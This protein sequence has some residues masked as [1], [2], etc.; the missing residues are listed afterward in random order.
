M[1]GFSNDWEFTTEW[2]EEFAR[3][4]GT[5]E[6]VRLPH[7]VKELPLHQIDEKSYQLISGYRKRFR[8]GPDMSTFTRPV[9]WNLT[10]TEFLRLRRKMANSLL[11]GL[12]T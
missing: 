6:K 4:E 1:I 8:L 9:Q 5:A 2:N 7:T 11:R 10:V 3:G 12:K